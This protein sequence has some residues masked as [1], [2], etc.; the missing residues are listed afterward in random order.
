MHERPTPGRTDPRGGAAGGPAW[1]P[2]PEGQ[3][4]WRYWD[5][6]AWTAW[7]SDGT[8]LAAHPVGEDPVRADPPAG[9]P[10]EQ[11]PAPRTPTR[12]LVAGWSLAA[13]GTML[14]VVGL[15]ASVY[16]G[17]DP[18]DGSGWPFGA[19]GPGAAVGAAEVGLVVA[20]CGSWVLAARHPDDEVLASLRLLGSVAVLALPAWVFAIVV[21]AGANCAL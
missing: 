10:A 21:L 20:A 8:S 6:R 7:T 11:G 16:T 9:Q 2:D 12:A 15:V 14:L 19:T 18:C 13:A 5:G 4:P 3:H 1:R 17:D